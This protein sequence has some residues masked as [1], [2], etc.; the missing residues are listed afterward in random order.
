MLTELVKTEGSRGIGEGILGNLLDCDAHL[1]MEPEVLEHIVGDMGGGFVLAYVKQ[2]I[3]TGQVFKDR[4]RNRSE[5]WAV[6]GLA[7]LGACE[8]EERVEAMN[9]MGIKAQLIFPNTALR[10]LRLDGESALAACRRYNDYA[11]D[12]TRKTGDRGRVVCQI[13]MS[14][15]EGAMAELDRVIR[16]GAKAVML[17]CARGPA[18]VSPAHAMWDPFWARIQEANIPALLHIGG[19]GLVTSDKD[20][21]IIPPREFA[22]APA[23]KAAFP[24]RPGAEEAIGPYFFLIAHMAPETWLVTMVMGG[25]FER[26]PNL[27]FGV[28]ECGASWVGPMAK[29][30]EMHTESMARAGVTFKMRP[31]E[32][33]RR[34]VR[35]TPYWQENVGEIVAQS[36]GLDEVYVFSTDY[37][38]LEGTRDPIGR[39]RRSMTNLDKSYEHDFFVEN[40]K[41]LFPDA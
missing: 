11:I 34:N 22:D 38:H 12:W 41:L 19:G 14:T 35:V 40:A 21:P 24:Y 10:E 26:F 30:M 37:P 17:P 13:N 15:V 32:Y 2:Q 23:L 39:L 8:A 3:A 25:V 5:L 29:R 36:N 20:D 16:N 28:I 6:K 9:A 1:Y 18:G 27:R 31:S 33:L 4:A 7:A